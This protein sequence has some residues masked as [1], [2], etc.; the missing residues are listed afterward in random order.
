MA[1]INNKFCANRFSFDEPPSTS[2]FLVMLKQLFFFVSFT[3][4]FGG[5]FL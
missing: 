3:T 4:S 1:F 5:D 2:K